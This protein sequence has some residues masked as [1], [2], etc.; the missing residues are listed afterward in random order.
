MKILMII[1]AFLIFSCNSGKN[2]E[3][4]E[5]DKK[6]NSDLPKGKWSNE[7][8]VNFMDDCISNAGTGM[9]NDSTQIYCACMLTKAQ[10]AYPNYDDVE[11][12]MTIQQ[13]NKWASECLGK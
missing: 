9:K 6:E 3:T 13:V 8:Q 11:K 1:S 2:K 10:T 7:E 5:T 12:K 4:G